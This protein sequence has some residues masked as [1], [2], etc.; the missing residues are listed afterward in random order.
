[1]SCQFLFET[2]YHTADQMQFNCSR[3]IVPVT[4]YMAMFPEIQ[5][6]F[7]VI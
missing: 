7:L 6:Y 4:N 2:L 5:C 3:P 1:M